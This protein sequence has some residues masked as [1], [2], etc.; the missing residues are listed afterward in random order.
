MKPDE[1][2]KPPFPVEP[3][4]PDLLEWARQTVNEEDILAD[5]REIEE[6]GG[7]ELKDFIDEIRAR[8]TPGE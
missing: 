2:R 3:I 7:F 4:P 8:A 6:T 1:P 5:L